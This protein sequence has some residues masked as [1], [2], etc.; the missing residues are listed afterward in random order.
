MIEFEKVRQKL[1]ELNIRYE[2]V[3]HEPALTTEQADRFIEGIEGVRTKTMFMTDKKK[4]AFFLVIMDDA[5]RL[6]LNRLKEILGVNQVKLAS[7]NTL[8]DKMKLPAGV[9]SPFGLLNNDDRDIRV[10]FDAE[11]MDE[12]RM[13]FHPNTNE[14]TIF[15]STADVLKFLQAI[16]YPEQTVA[17]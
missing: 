4:K 14:K 17:L 1:D 10:Y 8:Y 9:V 16:G 7:E 6:D 13:S 11:I 3:E 5:K 12:A 2:L 15:L